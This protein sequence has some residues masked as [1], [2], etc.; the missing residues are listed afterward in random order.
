MVDNG[1]LCTCGKIGCLETIA[2]VPAIARQAREG[3]EKGN[4]SLILSLVDDDQ[5]RI[6][7]GT[8]I[9]AARLGDQF[10]ISILTQA[11][12]WLGKGIAHLIQIF[13]PELIIIGGKV[14]EAGQFMLAPIQ[15]AIFTY[16]NS[17]ISS[18]TEIL[19][20]VLGVRA[21]AIGAAA[22]ALEKLT[23]S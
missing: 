17:D 11:G 12:F 5:E 7:T 21:G 2:S 22:Y 13:N 4:S 19:F 18:D 9:E 3:V 8:V 10:S 14:A 23:T 16:T 20:S 15:Q 6:T 1:I